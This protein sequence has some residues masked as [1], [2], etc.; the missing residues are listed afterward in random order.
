MCFKKPQ[1]KFVRFEGNED[2][3][4]WTSPEIDVLLKKQRIDVIVPAMREAVCALDGVVDTVWQPGRHQLVGDKKI[5]QQDLKIYFINKTVVVPVLWGTPSF[6]DLQDPVF[7][8]PVRFGARGTAK[9]SIDDVSKVLFKISGSRTEYTS[10]QLAEFFRPKTVQLFTTL[11]ATKMEDLNLSYFNLPRYLDIMSNVISGGMASEFA[12]YGM[13]LEDFTIDQIKIEEDT[14]KKFSSDAEMVRRFKLREKMYEQA[15]EEMRAD[16]AAD[17]D[18]LERM[19][20]VC[21]EAAERAK[22]DRDVTFVMPVIS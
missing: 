10:A 14:L 15:R 9:L 12:A 6:I 13:K 22:D 5:P 17:A 16:R 11:L 1:A 4:I 2:Q 19:I 3:I 21:G 7:E 20:R 8:M 18:Y